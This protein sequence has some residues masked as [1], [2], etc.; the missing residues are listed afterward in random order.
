[1]G[2]T[3]A[4]YSLVVSVSQNFGIVV[5][6]PLP[7]SGQFKVVRVVDV[8]VHLSAEYMELGYLHHH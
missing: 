4:F 7:L 2:S 5:I 1:M 8:P 6:Q 3:A